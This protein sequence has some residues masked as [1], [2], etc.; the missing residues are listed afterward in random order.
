MISARARGGV[1]SSPASRRT[2]TTVTLTIY[3]GNP[4]S[5]VTF[6]DVASSSSRVPSR[7]LDKSGGL[8]PSAAFVSMSTEE[9]IKPEL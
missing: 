7:S 8:R 3:G 2:R 6:E 5:R 4:V 9:K 1:L